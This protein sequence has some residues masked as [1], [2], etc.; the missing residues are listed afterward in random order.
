MRAS[1]KPRRFAGRGTRLLWRSKREALDRRRFK[2]DTGL[3]N[4]EA[5]QA[6]LQRRGFALA[7]S[8]QD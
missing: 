1:E 5:V 3:S 4:W 6:A 7:E 2:E 8:P